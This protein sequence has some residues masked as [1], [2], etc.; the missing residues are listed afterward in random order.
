MNKY[1]VLFNRINHIIKY[2]IIM[3]S[4]STILLTLSV[5]AILAAIYTMGSPYTSSAQLQSEDVPNTLQFTFKSISSIL[6]TTLS[7]V[8]AFNDTIYAG[9]NVGSVA[10]WTYDAKKKKL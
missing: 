8:Y 7:R 1:I 3:I 2:I 10:I 6:R 9:D 5:V 4:K